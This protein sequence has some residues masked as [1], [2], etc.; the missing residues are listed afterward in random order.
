MKERK[1]EFTPKNITLYLLG[2]NVVAV[3]VLF[4][5]RGDL[6]AG[7]WDTTTYGLKVLLNSVGI[8]ATLG[9]SSMTISFIIF[10]VVILYRKRGEFVLMLA[11]IILMGSMLDFWDLL[12]FQ[13]YYPSIVSMQIIFFLLGTVSIPLGLAM[14]IAS[15]FPAFVF[16]EWTIMM[17]EVLNIN[18]VSKIRVGIEVLGI[19]LGALFAFLAGHGLGAVSYGSVIVALTLP[20]ILSFFLKRFGVTSE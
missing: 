18:S 10:S 15:N 11:P 16:D 6:G 3:G 13:D 12:V 4:L 14:I 2:F 8:P 19:T 9:L 5:L 1:I 7:P 17:M 20:I